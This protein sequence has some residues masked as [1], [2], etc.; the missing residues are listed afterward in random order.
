MW[1]G[2]GWRFWYGGFWFNMY[3]PWFDDWGWDDDVYIDYDTDTDCYF[4]YNYHHPGFR[5]R[6][7]VVF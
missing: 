4:L 2:S 3:D 5:I 7:G 6:L 1:Y